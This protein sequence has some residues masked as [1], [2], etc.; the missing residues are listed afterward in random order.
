MCNH[1]HQ[2]GFTLVELAIVLVIIGLLLG[3]VLKGQEMI[4]NGKIKNLQNDVKGVTAAYYAYRD[5]YNAIPG[6]DLRAAARWTT[7]AAPVATSGDGNGIVGVAGT[8]T[9]CGASVLAPETCTFMHHLRLAGLITGINSADPTNAYGGA[10]RVQ[11]NNL[12]AL[13]AMVVGLNLCFGSLP[14]KAAEAIDA[15]FDD[16]NPATGNVRAA[17]GTNNF[18]PNT[19]ATGTNYVESTAVPGYT[20]C[21]LL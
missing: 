6:D 3:G 10:I 7:A 2:S 17:Q 4:E 19:T 5:R 11:Q 1:K 15:S 8:W 18:D 9:A 16:G 12:P 13:T 14:A 21:K 20:V